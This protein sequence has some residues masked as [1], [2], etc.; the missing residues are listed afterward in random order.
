M[1]KTGVKLVRLAEFAW[2][3]LEPK[4]GEFVFGWLDELMRIFARYGSYGYSD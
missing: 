2:S 1:A 3:K 4:D